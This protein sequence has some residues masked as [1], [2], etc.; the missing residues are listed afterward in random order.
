MTSSEG[1][2]ALKCTASCFVYYLLMWPVHRGVVM[3]SRQPQPPSSLDHPAPLAAARRC[4]LRCNAR[5]IGAGT[6]LS[7]SCGTTLTTTGS[8][9][10]LHA[11][12]SGHAS[13][14]KRTRGRHAALPIPARAR[15]CTAPPDQRLPHHVVIPSAPPYSPCSCTH[16]SG[17]GPPSP[18]ATAPHR[19]APAAKSCKM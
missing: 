15:G 16:C 8:V 1:H 19:P 12:C 18:S 5:C 14:A 9:H 11:S 2:K 4:W 7:T 13:S 3:H 17:G 6:H 10:V